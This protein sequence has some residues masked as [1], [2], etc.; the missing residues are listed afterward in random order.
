MKRYYL[1][2]QAPRRGSYGAALLFFIIMILGFVMLWRPSNQQ[3]E[4]PSSVPAI[5]DS[6]QAPLFPVKEKPTSSTRIWTKVIS[7]TFLLVV[8]FLLFY[9]V[10][11]RRLQVGKS[12]GLQ[13]KVLGRRYLDAK[14]SLVLIEVEGHRLLLG[15]TDHNIQL[16]KDF[17]TEEGGVGDDY[18]DFQTHLN[19]F[20]D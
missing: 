7:V 15:L 10:Y 3:P 14:H 5:V 12:P 13:A 20:E 17:T 18:K 1:G 11:G 4:Q 6:S 16:I 19:E 9:R 8:I 2:T